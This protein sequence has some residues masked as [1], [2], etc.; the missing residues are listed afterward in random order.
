MDK[1]KQEA[2]QANEINFAE[3]FAYERLD[4]LLS[5]TDFKE[6]ANEVTVHDHWA[7]GTPSYS[8]NTL[9][10]LKEFLLEQAEEAANA[11]FPSNEDDRLTYEQAYN[12]ERLVDKV[13]VKY[14]KE[15]II[16]NWI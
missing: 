15:L 2:E 1:R 14:A 16:L 7:S 12:N 13:L 9:P 10:D 11:G 8:F 6:Y 4:D 3:Q 5:V